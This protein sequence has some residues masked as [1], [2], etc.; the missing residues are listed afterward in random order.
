MESLHLKNIESIHYTDDASTFSYGLNQ[1]W[2]TRI[3]KRQAGCGPTVASTIH[4][5]LTANRFV[6]QNEDCSN[7]KNRI[8]LMNLMWSYITPTLSGVSNTRL[9]Q[10]KFQQFTQEKQINSVFDSIN[11]VKQKDRRLKLEKVIN[12]ISQAIAADCPIAFLNLDHGNQSEIDSWHWTI[13]VSITPNNSHS[14]D[15]DVLDNGT[16]KKLSLSSWYQTTRLGGGFVS[17]DYIAENI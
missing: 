16:L 4:C 7:H 2:Y 10:Q 12:F 17:V 9:F 8:E 11:I 13:I 6:K 15:V 1:D 5:Y 3:W 14:Y